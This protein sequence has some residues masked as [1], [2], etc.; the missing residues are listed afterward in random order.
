MMRNKLIIVLAVLGFSGMPLFPALSQ[1]Y[2]AGLP[3]DDAGNLQTM[4]GG[5]YATDMEGLQVTLN[6]GA[7][8]L[9]VDQSFYGY[10]VVDSPNFYM[11]GTGYE[12]ELEESYDRGQTWRNIDA[13]ITSRGGNS[14]NILFF[15]ILGKDLV[16]GFQAGIYRSSTDGAS[17]TELPYPPNLGP[18]EVSTVLVRGDSL[19]AVTDTAAFLSTDTARSWSEVDSTVF[20]FPI[21][22]SVSGY[23]QFGNTRY[24]PTSSTFVLVSHDDGKSWST[25]NAPAPVIQLLQIGGNL[26][27]I[28]ETTMYQNN[29][30]L[31]HDSGSSWTP[32]DYGIPPDARISEMT[33]LGP[34]LFVGGS[35]YQTSSD[36]VWKRALSD[37]N[38]N[39]AVDNSRNSDSLA[40]SPNPASNE[41]II[42]G[43][44]KTVEVFNL[45]GQPVIKMP[46]SSAS[47]EVID[48]RNQ[49]SGTYFACI[50]T[51]KGIVVRK[52]VKQ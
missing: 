6:Y 3:N 14:T 28:V 18:F 4:G 26:F 8:W 12:G 35:S 44:T 45:L 19:F 15:A 33:P 7:S 11:V 9:P 50:S 2:P 1:W 5:L 22:S 10:L 21:H 23:Y 32:V 41:V 29:L 38:S 52:I 49:P 16:L 36:A 20:G 34:Y 51:T 27:A 42:R 43:S 13:N 46:N 48:L 30:Y 40:L 47:E 17:W 25:I 31:S 39:S 37:F 24:A